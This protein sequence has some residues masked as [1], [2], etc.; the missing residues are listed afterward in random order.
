MS[1]HLCAHEGPD[2]LTDRRYVYTPRFSTRSLFFKKGAWLGRV[3][4]PRWAWTTGQGLFPSDQVLEEDG[5]GA[6]PSLSESPLPR[7]LCGA[8]GLLS[9]DA[10]HGRPRT[11]GT[12]GVRH[13]ARA[14]PLIDLGLSTLC[15]LGYGISQF[16]NLPGPPFPHA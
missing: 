2:T 10:P 5:A 12:S 11:L 7:P 3:Q 9:Q 8:A 4:S 16:F 13:T 6:A 15:H 1:R 14:W